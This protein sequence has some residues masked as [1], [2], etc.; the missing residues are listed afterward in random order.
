MLVVGT[1]Q[2]TPDAVYVYQKTSSG[3]TLMQK[4]G[5]FGFAVAIDGNR[6]IA[7]KDVFVSSESGTWLLEDTLEPSEYTLAF[8]V[9]ISGNT[10]VLAMQHLNNVGEVH[11][12][13]K[14]ITETPTNTVIPIPSSAFPVCAELFWLLAIG[15]TMFPNL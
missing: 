9:D 14:G 15:V 4:V 8:D 10:A 12:F 7:D 3:W 1:G 13:V 11:V 5:A 6:L 2:T